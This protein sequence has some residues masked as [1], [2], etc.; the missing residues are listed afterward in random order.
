MKQSETV[1]AGMRQIVEERPYGDAYGPKEPVVERP[2]RTAA[3][4]ARWSGERKATGGSERDRPVAH[5]IPEQPLRLGRA[6]RASNEK[7]RKEGEA[8]EN[9]AGPAVQP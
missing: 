5:L 3:G 8:D 2:E 1:D 6:H 7:K 9:V 4:H